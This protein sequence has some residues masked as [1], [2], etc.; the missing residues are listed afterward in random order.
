MTDPETSGFTIEKLTILETAIADGV[1]TVSYSDKTVTYRSLDEMLRIR[2]MMR[3]SLGLK[4]TGENSG[5]FGGKRIIPRH[6]KGL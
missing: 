1:L 4:E 2:N 3:S 6:S 5:L